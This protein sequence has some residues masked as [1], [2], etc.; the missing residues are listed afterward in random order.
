MHFMLEL[1]TEIQ[2]TKLYMNNSS[3]EENRYMVSPY[4]CSCLLSVVVYGIPLCL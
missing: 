3:I 4:V 2:L 1:H